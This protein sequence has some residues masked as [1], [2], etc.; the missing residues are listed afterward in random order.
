MC[1]YIYYCMQQGLQFFKQH[2]HV[3][4]ALQAQQ[5]QQAATS[6][7]ATATANNESAAS[8]S[9]SNSVADTCV[10]EPLLQ[11]GYDYWQKQHAA[12][13]NNVSTFFRICCSLCAAHIARPLY[14]QNLLASR[15][16]QSHK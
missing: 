9:D 5:Q 1:V 4:P 6:D 16:A 2:A 14:I 8:S 7:A 13:D 3:S 15:F 11:D 10:H 12:Q